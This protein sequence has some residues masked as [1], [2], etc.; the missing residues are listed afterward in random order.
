[1]SIFRE[2]FLQF[3]YV[4]AAVDFPFSDNTFFIAIFLGYFSFVEFQDQLVKR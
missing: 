1:M 4:V 3:L 2:V